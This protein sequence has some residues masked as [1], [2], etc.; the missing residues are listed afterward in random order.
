MGIS[1]VLMS[2]TSQDMG[3]AAVTFRLFSPSQLITVDCSRADSK[4]VEGPAGAQD[5]PF[6]LLCAL[7][8]LPS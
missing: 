5:L 1:V 6:F 3:R 4:A 7:P 8:S 2:S